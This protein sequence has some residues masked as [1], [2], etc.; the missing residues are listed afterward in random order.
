MAT[1][2]IT[3]AQENPWAEEPGAYSLW[4]SKKLEKTERL[5]HNHYHACDIKLVGR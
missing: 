1:H 5:N 4:G 2:A 3:L